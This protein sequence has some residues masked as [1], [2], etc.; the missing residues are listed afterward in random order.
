MEHF[1]NLGSV[2]SS[3]ATA[4]K[5]LDNR[6]SKARNSF[7][8]LSNRVWQSHSLRLSRKIQ[9]DRAL[10]IPTLLYDVETWAIYRKQIR[11]LERFH[12]VFN[13]L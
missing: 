3:Y 6:L 4:S 12:L 2:I 13:I 11:L 8:R 7:G 1:T 9:V 10:V 5:D